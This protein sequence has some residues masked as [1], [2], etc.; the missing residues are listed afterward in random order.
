MKNAR[1]LVL[2][3]LLSAL[4]LVAAACAGDDGNGEDTAGDGEQ[5]ECDWAIG[6]MGALSGDFASLGGPIRDGV[7]YAVDQANEA[8]EVPCE[9]SLVEEDSQGNPDQAP[10]LAQ[11]LVE[12]EELVAVAGPYFSG[13]TLAVG[14][15]FS[16]SGVLISGTGT[17]ETIDEQGYETWFRAVAPDNIQGEVAAAYISESLGGGTVAVIHDNQDYSKGLADSVLSNLGDA[18]GPF[19]INPEETDYSSVVQQVR[20]V[21]PDIVYYGGYTPQAGPLLQ[22]LTEAGVEAQFLSDD[23]AKDPSFGELAGESAQ[24]AQ[25]TCP[26]TDPTKQENASDFVEG[27]GAEYGEDAPGTFAADMFD[28]TNIIIEAL[29]ELNGDEDIEEVRAHVIE[30]FQNAEGIEGVAKSYSWEDNG[31]FVGGPED[32]W[33]YEWDNDEGDFV[34]LGPASDLIGQ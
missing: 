34:S 26:C 19:I 33:V 7:A 17:N 9:L 12:N 4:A 23:G 27:M 25:V 16:E 13:E 24:G 14:E 3:S 20:D 29:G 21:E 31:E 6:T 10:A 30:Y 22:Q 5:I 18:E 1:F 2:I 32:I 11:S 28:V 8:G 15:I